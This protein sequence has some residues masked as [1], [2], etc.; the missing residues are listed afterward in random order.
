VRTK[1]ALSQAT[2]RL[3]VFEPAMAASRTWRRLN[4]EPR[5]PMLLA[6]IALTDGA[7]TAPPDHRAARSGPITQVRPWLDWDRQAVE[8]GWAA[9]EHT[10]RGT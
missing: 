6:G 8:P 7:A 2:A 9:E 3:M 5:A 10:R 1:G 4:G